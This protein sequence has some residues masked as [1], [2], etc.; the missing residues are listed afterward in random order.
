VTFDRPAPLT[1]QVEKLGGK[2]RVTDE[3][4][5]RNDLSAIQSEGVKLGNDIQI[6][7]TPVRWLNWTHRSPRSVRQCS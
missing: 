5:D 4:R 6:S 1:A 3:A 2:F 7:C